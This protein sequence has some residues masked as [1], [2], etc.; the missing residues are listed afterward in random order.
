[1]EGSFRLG[2]SAWDW[3]LRSR[4]APHTGFAWEMIAPAGRIVGSGCWV[5]RGARTGFA[6]VLDMTAG[7]GLPESVP[8]LSEERMCRG[9]QRE[10]MPGVDFQRMC[11]QMSF[12]TGFGIVKCDF[13]CEM[14]G[15]CNKSLF[16]KLV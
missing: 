10:N 6:V 11:H 16:Y 9:C 15:Q 12:V 7:V 8:G 2:I 14:T 13:A 1:M 4:T 5:T 3:W